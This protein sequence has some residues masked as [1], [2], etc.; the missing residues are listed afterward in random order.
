[1]CKNQE[2]GDKKTETALAEVNL[3]GGGGWIRA[4]IGWNHR[5]PTWVSSYYI[6]TIY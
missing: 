4:A 1:M 6:V 5:S 3:L 2:V